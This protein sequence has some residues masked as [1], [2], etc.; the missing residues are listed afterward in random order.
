MFLRVAALAAFLSTVAIPF[1]SA[2]DH[3]LAPTPPMGWNSWDAYGLTIDEADYRANTKVL[4]SM[5]KYGWEYSV[6]DEGWYM[7]NPFG[8]T[9]EDRKDVWN[10]NGILIP[11]IDRFP[12]SANGAGFK[13]LADWVHQQGLKFGI[14]ILRGIPR[15]VV[16]ENLPI[17]G[18][19]FHA[20][21]AADLNATC[22]WNQDNYGIK[23]NAAGQAYYDSMMKL[24]ASWG[25][26]FIKVDC[27]SDHPYRP[28]EI[29]QIALAIKHSGRPILLSL[30]PGPTNIEHAAEVAKYAQMWRITD[31]H[32]DGWDFEHHGTSEFPLGLS[33]EFDRIA[34]WAPY[35]K[36]GAWPDPDMLPEGYL[37][38]H[39]G[40]GDAR[41]SR[42]THDEQRSEFTLWA[43][44]RSPLIMGAN[45]TKLDDFTR[46]LMT[47]QEVLDLNQNAVETGPGI[48]PMR[49]GQTDTF[50]ERFW[51][52]RTGGVHG[53][54]YIA[55]FN[56]ENH[57][58]SSTLPWQIFHLSDKPHAVYDVWNDKHRLK[59]RALKVDLPP[60]GCALFRVE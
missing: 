42:Y 28:S 49:N 57:P 27:I 2:G 31:D 12:S 6:I 16:K 34:K 11:A 40:W 51:Y 10:A 52:A 58:T 4:A 13:P 9:V 21:D 22:P 1:L 39:P 37:G 7:Q 14:H 23:D 60:H 47:N 26:D 5:H 43:I 33:G 56:L 15:Q 20:A 25:L 24:Y 44:S 29:R 53:K 30:S 32:W 50:P 17:A 55:V 54:Y 3:K 18:T 19:S 35:T 41:Q 48:L 46:S 36:P 38:P 59:S 45:L 8:A